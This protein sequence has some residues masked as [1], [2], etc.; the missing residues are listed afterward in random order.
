MAIFQWN[1]FSVDRIMENSQVSSMLEYVIF[2]G[3]ISQF[4][5]TFG[6]S[7]TTQELFVAIPLSFEHFEIEP[8]K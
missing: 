8:C 7:P 2:Y 3:Q 5:N 1:N 4:L 6:D